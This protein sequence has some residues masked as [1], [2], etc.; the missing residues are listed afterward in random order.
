M[1]EPGNSTD[2]EF[3]IPELQYVRLKK[4]KFFQVEDCCQEVLYQ[5]LQGRAGDWKPITWETLL[6]AMVEAQCA[7]VAQKVWKAIT[8]E[9]KLCYCCYS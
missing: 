4:A 2:H 9:G 8:D 3:T 5:W 7:T 6:L 1:V